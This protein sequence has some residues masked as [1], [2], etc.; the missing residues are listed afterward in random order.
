[1]YL[2]PGTWI[3][4]P[5]KAKTPIEKGVGEDREVAV[6]TTYVGGARAVTLFTGVHQLST[7]GAAYWIL[8]GRVILIQVRKLVSSG[9]STGWV[10]GHW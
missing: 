10:G 6:G 3:R 2:S 4:F 5:R 8:M 7:H 9:V 1:M